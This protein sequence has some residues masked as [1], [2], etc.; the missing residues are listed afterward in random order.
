MIINLENP[1]QIKNYCKQKHIYLK[2]M[3]LIH[4]ETIAF[5]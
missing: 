2:H 1:N 3:K 5:L 4:P